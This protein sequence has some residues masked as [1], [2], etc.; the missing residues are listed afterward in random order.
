MTHRMLKTKPVA[1]CPACSTATEALNGSFAWLSSTYQMK[2]KPTAREARRWST[3]KL[4]TCC[5]FLHANDRKTSQ[6]PNLRPTMRPSTSTWPRAQC[7]TRVAI[8]S[9]LWAIHGRSRWLVVSLQNRSFSGWGLP[10][11]DL[12]KND[13]AATGSGPYVSPE[14]W[15]INHPKQF[16]LN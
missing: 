9:C 1:F 8:G 4:N 6:K 11:C 5:F 2:H 16:H 13:V 12:P 10:H 7:T 14:I 3:E 15:T